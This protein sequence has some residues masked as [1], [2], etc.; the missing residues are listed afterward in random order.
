MLQE[1]KKQFPNLPGNTV[2]K[3]LDDVRGGVRCENDPH[4]FGRGIGTAMCKASV[5]WA[6]DHDYAAVL[7]P[8]APDGLFEFAAWSGHLPSTTYTKLGF[9]AVAEEEGK[10]L[11][12]WAKGDSPP[13]V[14]AQI[15]AALS[16]GR[17]KSEI[18]ERLMLLDLR[19]HVD[20]EGR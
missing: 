8:G 11:P 18:R 16:A 3:V 7:A 2:G 19:S 1:I 13:Q 6:R 9:D 12:K 5:Q 4:Y 10:D 15:R 14:M 20:P 17:P